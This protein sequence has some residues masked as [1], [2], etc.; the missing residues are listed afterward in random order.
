MRRFVA[1][2]V[3]LAH[4]KT[5]HSRAH[6]SI[7][8]AMS[9]TRARICVARAPSRD[10]RAPRRFA[11]ACGAPVR[12]EVFDCVLFDGRVCAVR[13]VTR[14][15]DALIVAALAR[16]DAADGVWFEDD[17]VEAFVVTREACVVVPSEYSQRM[18]RDRVKNPHG[19][20][21][22]DCWI[23]ADDDAVGS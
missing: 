19:E 10:W 14:D 8:R 17:A 11:R 1:R 7:A 15:D 5:S 12:A 4:P 13:D 3:G 2:G 18:Q 23:I 22:E 16:E 20:H 6:A 9:S 21:A